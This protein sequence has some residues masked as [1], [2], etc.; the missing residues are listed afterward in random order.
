M[1]ASVRPLRRPPRRTLPARQCHRWP[2][3]RNHH[4][5]R[6]RANRPWVGFIVPM[7]TEMGNPLYGNAF[8]SAR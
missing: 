6:H 8:R 7:R 3:R 2:E 4:R 5:Y 1:Q